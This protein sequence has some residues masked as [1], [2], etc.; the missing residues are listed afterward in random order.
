M[1]R[2]ALSWEERTFL[3][4]LGLP[5]MGIALAYALVTM[6][7]PVFI[8]KQ[9]GAAVTGFMIGGE[10]VFALFIP[11]LIGGWSDSLRAPRRM[12]F[13]FAGTI[14]I[15]ITLISMPLSSNS[16]ILLAIELALFF[17]GYFTHYAAY[18]ALFPDYVPE[19]ERG[20]SQGIQGGFRS[21]GLLLSLAGGGFL[22]HISKFLPFLIV[23]F[24][25]IIVT[26][27]LYFGIRPRITRSGKATSKHIR[28]RAGWELIHDNPH[29]FYWF[30]ANTLWE[31]AIAVLKVFV[32]LYFTRGLHFTLSQ[33]SGALS[34]VGLAAI[35]AAPIAGALADKYGHR[36]VI[37][38]SLIFFALG[39][40]P[41][42][43]TSNTHFIAGI[44]PVAFSAV[45]L[46]TLPYSIL[47]N[48]LP[49]AES[50]GAGAA[51]FGLSQ[52]IGALIGPLIAGIV[53]E[54]LKNVNILAFADTHGYAAIYPVASIFLIASIPFT[55]YL[56]TNRSNKKSKSKR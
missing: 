16:L 40:I 31:C 20:R 11:F 7:L 25:Q 23:A 50:H 36:P 48:L 4:I 17:I 30:I 2:N 1:G 52:G 13:I 6:Y 44:I 26:I 53:I 27:I 28:W 37:I 12:P 5:S 39:L 14:I 46:M 45:V 42:S 41:P 19:K 9:S 34:L 49:K 29:I 18:Y 51:L 15:V 54:L 21:F 35:F 38:L 56:F 55:F 47:M 10:G 3:L 32:V 33:T 24:A 8:E 22:L 43:F